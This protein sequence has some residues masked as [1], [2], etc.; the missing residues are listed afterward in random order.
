MTKYTMHL[1]LVLTLAETS[2]CRTLKTDANSKAS[3]AVSSGQ[4]DPVEGLSCADKTGTIDFRKREVFTYEAAIADGRSVSRNPDGTYDIDGLTLLI[5]AQ[6]PLNRN[7]SQNIP[8]TFSEDYKTLV[9]NAEGSAST[10][11]LTCERLVLKPAKQITKDE[12]RARSDIDQ[13]FMFMAKPGELRLQ[14]V[15]VGPYTSEGEGYRYGLELYRDGHF[16]A[17][18]AA[19]AY[20]SYEEIAAQMQIEL[21]R[22]K[23]TKLITE[24]NNLGQNLAVYPRFLNSRNIIPSD[25]GLFL[26]AGSGDKHQVRYNL[27]GESPHLRIEVLMG[28][29]TVLSLPQYP[30]YD[31]DGKRIQKIFADC[32]DNLQRYFV[33]NPDVNLVVISPD[34]SVA[35]FEYN[36]PTLPMTA[37]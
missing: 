17:M 10:R 3:G 1:L 29:K 33:N 14:V 22:R 4:K 25:T 36:C 18:V 31:P 15:K 12:E 11:T 20:S 34:I 9:L 26:P 5:K 28:D 7:K 37:L 23:F 30:S 16:V 32:Q 13:P 8:G 19:Y 2:A 21:I 24:A 27:V 35:G 6:I